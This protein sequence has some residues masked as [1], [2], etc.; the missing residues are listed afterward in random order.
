MRGGKRQGAGRPK[1]SVNKMSAELKEMILGALEESGG[2]AYLVEQAKSSPAA[3]MTLLGKVLPM[4]V[5][6]DPDSPLIPTGITINLRAS[7]S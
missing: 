2:Q 4:T 1:G 3:F 5:A 7:G 6:S